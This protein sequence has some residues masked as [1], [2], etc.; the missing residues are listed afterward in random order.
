MSEYQ[1][2]EFQAIDQPLDQ[3]AQAELREIT[4][5][6]D[7]TSRHL[8]NEYHWGDFKGNPSTLMEQYFDAFLYYANWGT[9][10]LMLR[11]PRTNFDISDSHPYQADGVVD[12]WQTETHVI[13]S[14]SADAEPEWD[15]AWD[16]L[17]VLISIRED[18]MAGDLRSLYLGWLSGV[19][20][21]CHPDDAVE[22]PI[23]PGMGKLSHSLRK[24]AE[25]LYVEEALLE[26]ASKG[27]ENLATT[28]PSEKELTQW[29]CG[30]P[31]QE[32]DEL[33]SRVILGQ[34]PQI[35]ME[36]VRRYR[37]LDQSQQDV[38]SSSGRTAGELLAQWENHA[39]EM[40]RIE[41]EK[42]EKEQEARERREAE[43][44]ASYLQTLKGKE[45]K[46]WTEIEK[47]IATKQP[48]N[49]DEAVMKLK[50]LSEIAETEKEK[51]TFDEKMSELRTRHA[52]KSTLIERLKKAGLPG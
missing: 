24:L 6:A 13:F 37:S 5:R 39:D 36:L 32:K 20:R 52:R 25:F 10:Q 21:D 34:A 27:S 12:V 9:H 42:R 19:T 16:W 43:E 50:D 40:E 8:I 14:F 48:K 15:E 3:N 26:I 28:E 4:S 49:Y 22:P 2:Y 1:Y 17:D 29:V 51:R 31:V 45:A 46:L 38:G 47:L 7:I 33:L 18:L 44:R 11:V 30:L 23:P 35:Q 41:E